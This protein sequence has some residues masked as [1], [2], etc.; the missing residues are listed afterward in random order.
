[1]VKYFSSSNILECYIKHCLAINQTKSVS[2]SQEGTYDKFQHFKRFQKAPFLIY[3]DYERILI[4]SSDNS[5][6]KKYK[7]HIAYSHGYKLICV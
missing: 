7:N 2:L 5:T 1:M 3:V 6:L 4:P